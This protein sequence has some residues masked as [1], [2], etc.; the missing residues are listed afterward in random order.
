VNAIKGIVKFFS[1]TK[2]FGF[3]TPEEGEDVFV[4]I[5]ALGDGMTIQE[6]DEVMFDVEDSDR[7]KKAANVKFC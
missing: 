4:H 2:G 1:E 6:N 3:I 7:G 5:S